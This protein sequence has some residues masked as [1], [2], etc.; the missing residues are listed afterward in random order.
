MPLP[1]VPESVLQAKCSESGAT[2]VIGSYQ[3]RKKPLTFICPC[4]EEV[5]RTWDK[6]ASPTAWAL[7]LPCSHKKQGHQ[8]TAKAR[9]LAIQLLAPA[10]M[11]SE[12]KNNYTFFEALCICGNKFETHLLNLQ[13][14]IVPHCRACAKKT[15]G[16]DPRIEEARQR[17]SNLATEAGAELIQYINYATPLVFKCSCGSVDSIKPGGLSPG[18]EVKATFLCRKCRHLSISREKHPNYK[19]NKTD[20][21]RMDDRSTIEHRI[22]IDSVLKR[23]NYTCVISGEKKDICAHH[24]DNYAQFPEGRFEVSNGVTLSRKLHLEF[25]NEFCGGT[26]KG[27]TSEQF[28]EF[29][30]L[31]TGL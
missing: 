2:Y 13:M 5:K 7:C 15:R 4:G 17:I 18:K 25:H 3:S 30:A 9:A 29:Y 8:G 6:L 19:H 27:C 21:E 14:G 22:W 26:S 31:K 16:I 12:Y 20:E 28:R 23:D 11:L 1:K 10:K 24:L